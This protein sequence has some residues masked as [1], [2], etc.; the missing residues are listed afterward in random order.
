[1]FE[2]VVQVLLIMPV[3]NYDNYFTNKQFFKRK[4]MYHTPIFLIIDV[5]I[6]CFA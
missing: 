4:V 3:Y 1:M 5:D 6:L 2:T